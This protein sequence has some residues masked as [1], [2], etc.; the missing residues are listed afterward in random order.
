VQEPPVQV[1][2]SDEAWPQVWPAATHA[3]PKQQAPPEQVLPVQQAA[4]AAPQAVQ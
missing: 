2:A 3:P 4:P 1:P